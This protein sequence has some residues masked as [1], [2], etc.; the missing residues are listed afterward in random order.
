MT[1]LAISRLRRLR[2]E[3]DQGAAMLIAL[4]SMMVLTTLSLMA[5]GVFLAQVSPSQFQDKNER[6]INS[7]EAGLEAALGA[8]RNA[9]SPDP[10]AAGAVLGDRGKLPCWTDYAGQ[11]GGTDRTRSWTA[12]VRYYVQDPAG[13]D[14]AWR[15][16]NDLQCDS[17][18]GGTPVTPNYA[19]VQSIGSEDALPGKPA[20][21]GNRQLETIYTFRLTDQNVSGGAIE[22][23]GMCFDA[24]SG[25][26]AIGTAAKVKN[27]AP[28]TAPQMW[29][30]RTDFTIQLTATQT[31]SSVLGLCLSADPGL[32]GALLDV[33]VTMQTC[34]PTDAKQRWG[35]GDARE[36][37]GRLT[38]SRSIRWCLTAPGTDGANLKA[39]TTSCPQ[40]LPEPAVGAGGAGTT[41]NNIDGVP[42]Q[43][44]NYKEFG[45]CLD[46]TDW[47]VD[48][49]PYPAGR[50]SEIA[51]PCKQD[52]MRD[53]HPDAQPG[54]N[55]VFTYTSVNGHFYL[56]KAAGAG[57]P[58]NPANPQFCMRSAN[59]AGAYVTFTACTPA[60]TTANLKWTV[61]RDTGAANT[62][63]TIVDNYG[64]CL[65][66]GPQNLAYPASY[67]YS[68]IVTATCD[69]SM[70]QKWNAPP[71][72]QDAPIDNTREIPVP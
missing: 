12:T 62:N 19:L 61:N 42:L 34:D 16:A 6:T 8:I 5:L 49:A 14:D 48:P 2:D 29:A 32:L 21:L 47:I 22:I 60:T 54:W 27:C 15:A 63:Y 58:S 66:V 59:V 69:G 71:G 51:Y 40:A 20:R 4:M 55:E 45:R 46:I 31:A 9:V 37:F 35:I 3:G 13:R 39:N 70:G 25:A 52:P 10:T 30:F 44:V 11:V 23:N 65:A 1:G 43:W 41:S 24:G 17:T 36:L 26:P 56:N 72:L 7:A 67:R 28:G 57:P 53:S 64:R 18:R 33:N 68:S 50:P 38:Q